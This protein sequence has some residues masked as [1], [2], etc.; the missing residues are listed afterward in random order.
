MKNNKE[1]SRYELEISGEIVYANYRREGNI[2]H[3]DYVFAPEELRGSGAAGKL[4]EEVAKMAREEKIK[5]NPI[6]GYAVMWLKRHKE[7]GDLVV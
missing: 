3:I 6:C 1:L 4:M 7:Y 5:I 2:L